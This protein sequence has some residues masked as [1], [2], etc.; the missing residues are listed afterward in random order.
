MNLSPYGRFVVTMKGEGMV[1]V[2]GIGAAWWAKTPTE[3]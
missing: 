3:H 1:G 2:L